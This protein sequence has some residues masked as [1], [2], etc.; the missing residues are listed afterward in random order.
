MPVTRLENLRGEYDPV[1]SLIQNGYSNG[2]FVGNFLFPIAEVDKK[3]GKIRTFGKEHLRR[4]NGKRAVGA[5]PTTLSQDVITYSAYDAD[6]YCYE[7]RLDELEEDA[8]AETEYKIAESNVKILEDVILLEEEAQIASMCQTGANFTNTVTLAGNN[9]WNV[10]HADSTPIT[11]IETGMSA[12]RLATGHEANTIVC[13]YTSY[14]SLKNHST[15]IARIQYS[16]I[17]ITTPDIVGALFGTPENPV[18]VHVGSSIY[19]NAGTITDLWGDACIIAYVPPSP[20]EMA[21]VWTPGF[22]YSLHQKGKKEMRSYLAHPSGM[23]KANMTTDIFIP[24]FSM[25]K[26]GYL[27]LDCNA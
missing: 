23:V 22:G 27:I 25:E 14:K 26:S 3:H 16:Q 5:D 9:Q 13:G 1:L 4:Y 10:V 19:D 15:I 7:L 6:Q 18:K 12:I 17:G 2:L 21:N 24:K 11:D 8:A 20:G